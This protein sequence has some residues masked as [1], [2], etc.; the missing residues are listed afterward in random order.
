[1]EAE[2]FSLNAAQP[3]LTVTYVRFVDGK[4]EAQRGRVPGMEA[5]RAGHAAGPPGAPLGHLL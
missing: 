1:M 4:T 3:G 5:L 2:D